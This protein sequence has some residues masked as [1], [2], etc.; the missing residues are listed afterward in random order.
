MENN[1]YNTKSKILGNFCNRKKGREQKE[2]EIKTVHKQPTMDQKKL[3][4]FI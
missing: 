4:T 3:V 2:E 1:Q